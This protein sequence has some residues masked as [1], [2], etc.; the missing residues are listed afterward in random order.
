MSNNYN[1]NGII[2]L[3]EAVME[4]AY[5]DLESKDEEIKAD[6]EDFIQTMKDCYGNM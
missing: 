3:F 6:A 1:E 4:Q 5:K 2:N